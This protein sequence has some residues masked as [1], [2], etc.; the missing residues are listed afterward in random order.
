MMLMMMMTTTMMIVVVEKNVFGDDGL[1]H[2]LQVSVN[3]VI[4]SSIKCSGI[5]MYAVSVVCKNIFTGS[6]II[7]S[8]YPH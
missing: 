7:G 4:S 1:P 5:L 8:A 3:N 2:K 6:T